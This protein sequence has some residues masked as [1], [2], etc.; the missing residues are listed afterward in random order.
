MTVRRSSAVIVLGGAVLLALAPMVVS[1]YWLSILT[2]GLIFALLAASLDLLAGY[3][4]MPSL[5]HG[6]FFGIGSYGVAITITRYGW[7]PWAAAVAGVAVAAGAGLLFGAI[8]VRARGIYF[9]VITLAFGQVLWGGAVKWTDF[10]GGYN[11]I[12]G[13]SRPNVFGLDL[14]GTR[15]MYYAV[16][17]VVVVGM[18]I[19]ARLVA[20][21]IGLTLQGIRSGELRMG[22]IGYRTPIYR[23]A[24]FALAAGFAG[25]AGV[26]NVYYMRFAGPDNLFWVLSAQ[27]LLMV[28][29]GSAGTLWGPAVAGVALILAQNAISNESDRWITVLGL[30]YIFTVL[31][32]PGG[33]YRL[34]VG[35]T[36]RLVGTARSRRR[37]VAT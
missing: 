6:A 14:G 23:W 3:T 21:P 2:Q 32:A 30:L 25:L 4:G 17:V 27:V 12:A 19:L 7:G 37:S 15:E 8:A 28:I 22:F 20:S 18:A 5:G 11:G 31:L 16:L 35:S 26:L 24:I 1:G 34:A 33:L 36:R 13:I 29:I 10:T 9:L